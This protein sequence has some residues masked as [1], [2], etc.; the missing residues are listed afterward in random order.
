M[1]KYEVGY[2][3]KLVAESNMKQTGQPDREHVKL[4]NIKIQNLDV[5]TKTNCSHKIMKRMC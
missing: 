5:V 1:M 4:Q 3:D 2:F